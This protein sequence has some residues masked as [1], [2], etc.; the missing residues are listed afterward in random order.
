MIAAMEWPGT[1]SVL[2]H[3]LRSPAAVIA[4]YAHMLSEERLS[5]EDRRKA[6]VQISRAAE[7]VAL[8]AQQTADIAR[9]LA[10]DGLPPGE[11][12]RL[13]VVLGDAVAR[14]ADPSSVSIELTPEA[15]AVLI[16]IMDRA[17]FSAA[18][19]TIIDAVSREAGEGGVRL[20]ARVASSTGTCDLLVGEALL[21]DRDDPVAEEPPPSFAFG[22][23]GGLGL[24]FVVAATVLAAHGG[25]LWTIG[26]SR[27]IIGISFAIGR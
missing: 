6:F 8:I 24:A 4:G 16:R 17:A 15:D 2:A 5:D 26:A 7:R 14:R 12:V 11:P 21:L 20:K 23:Q 19:G 9:W 3:E 13:S 22:A 27:K 25:R 1:L 10:T 18:L